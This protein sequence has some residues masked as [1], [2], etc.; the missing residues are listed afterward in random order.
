MSLDRLVIY[1]LKKNVSPAE[2][3]WETKLQLHL[4]YITLTLVLSDSPTSIDKIVCH[5]QVF[6]G[7]HFSFIPLTLAWFFCVWEICPSPNLI[8]VIT[9]KII[10]FSALRVVFL[11]GS[12]VKKPPGM[13][14]TQ[15]WSLSWEDPGGGDGKPLQYSCVRDP[16]DRGAW[17]AIVHRVSK[18]SHDWATEQQQQRLQEHARIDWS[19]ST[20]H[21]P[22]VIWVTGNVCDYTFQELYL[23][24]VAVRETSSFLQ[25]ID[26]GECGV[27][28]GCSPLAN[29][30]ESPYLG[31]MGCGD[32]ANPG[33]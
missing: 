6:L 31:N 22:L 23:S 29:T 32:R 21:I 18:K 9:V 19:Q 12:V 15:V 17:R 25:L 8:C 28:G 16:M 27:W 33:K 3:K 2:G 7:S 30:V 26:M 10:L 14:E 20:Y 13:Q 24:H 4:R 5:G 11:G 1:W